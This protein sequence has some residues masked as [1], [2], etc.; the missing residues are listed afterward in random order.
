MP[1]EYSSYLL[2]PPRLTE[3]AQLPPH[4]GGL[5]LEPFRGDLPDEIEPFV[6]DPWQDAFNDEMSRSYAERAFGLPDVRRRVEGRRFEV[7]GSSRFGERGKDE[8]R[9]VV[10]VAYDYT[11]DL[12]IEVTLDEETGEFLDV[13]EAAYQPAL[14]RAEIDRAIDLAMSDERLA[15]ARDEGLTAGVIPLG[16]HPDAANAGRRLV[17]VMVSCPEDRLARYR[18]LVDLTAHRVVT[19]GKPGCSCCGGGNHE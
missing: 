11:N 14:C 16:D 8:R 15:Q 17:E 19:V 5:R 12:A 13:V 18:V 7:I 10:A 3:P 6:S 1:D 4:L 9:R 2:P